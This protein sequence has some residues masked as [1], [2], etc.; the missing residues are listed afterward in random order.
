MPTFWAVPLSA[1]AACLHAAISA[2][3]RFANFVALP[4]CLATSTC[5]TR[6]LA[7]SVTVGYISG[8][9]YQSAWLDGPPTTGIPAF[10]V[11]AENAGTRLSDP[12]RMATTFWLMK[13]LTTE[14]AV[15]G[16][17]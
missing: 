16:W 3:Y 6:P 15:V 11:A 9:V 10:A 5:E 7:T 17:P 12:A 14:A 4:N 13:S 8:L 1:G 2:Q